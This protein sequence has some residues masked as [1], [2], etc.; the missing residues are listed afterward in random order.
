MNDAYEY[1]SLGKSSKYENSRTHV[2]STMS[3]DVQSL[4][5]KQPVHLLCRGFRNKEV[6]FAFTSYLLVRCTR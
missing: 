2:I 5:Y 4:N 3:L 1:W 6:E